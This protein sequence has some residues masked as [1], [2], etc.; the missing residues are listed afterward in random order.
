MK[1]PDEGAQ[2]FTEEPGLELSDDRPPT[3]EELERQLAD[4][5]DYVEGNAQVGSKTWAALST[6]GTGAH[7]H[8]R[9][10][11]PQGVRFIAGFEGFRANLYNDAA[12]HATIGYGH[13]VHRGPVNGSEPAEFKA[14]ISQERALQVLAQDAA[15]AAGE[16]NRSATHPLSQQQFDALVSSSSTAGAAPL[17][18]PRS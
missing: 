1:Q 6:P 15:T 9:T 17:A 18:P 13:L 14:G 11:S 4:H 12:G 5:P 10:L 7:P 3:L 2:R 16:V 8:S